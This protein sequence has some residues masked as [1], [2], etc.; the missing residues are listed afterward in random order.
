MPFDSP[1]CF[2]FESKSKKHVRSFLWKN[3][4]EKEKENE[5]LIFLFIYF[6]ENPPNTTRK[7]YYMKANGIQIEI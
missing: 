6:W 5:K 4:K 2:F 3:E 1:R 7:N